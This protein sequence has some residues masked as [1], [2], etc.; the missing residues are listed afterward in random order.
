M[1]PTGLEKTLVAKIPVKMM[2]KKLKPIGSKRK[3][4][5][6]TTEISLAQQ[7]NIQAPESKEYSGGFSSHG[8]TSGY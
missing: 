1:I 3:T 4:V 5:K 2:V 6:R 7:S 8:E